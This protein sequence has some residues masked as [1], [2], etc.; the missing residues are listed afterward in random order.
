MKSTLNSHIGC[1]VLFESSL[2]ARFHSSVK[3]FADLSSLVFVIDWRG[4]HSF[5]QIYFWTIKGP[6][7]LV[8]MHHLH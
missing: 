7:N 2:L 5:F 1:G 6:P 8:Q 4:V 3:T